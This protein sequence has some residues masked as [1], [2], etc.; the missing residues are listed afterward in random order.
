MK[1]TFNKFEEA[2][3]V[4]LRI[5]N[6]LW[7]NSN[8][9]RFG[10]SIFQQGGSSNQLDPTPIEIGNLQTRNG[11]ALMDVHKRQRR[12]ALKN[13]ACFYATN[14]NLGHGSTKQILRLTTLRPDQIIIL[15]A[16]SISKP[17]RLR[18]NFF[19]I[20]AGRTKWFLTKSQ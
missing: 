14:P 6:A 9:G 7:G 10:S 19:Q 16:E 1:T 13:D 5:D 11:G 4:A 2:G 3:K 17:R 20:L 15:D 12:M 8:S 18:K